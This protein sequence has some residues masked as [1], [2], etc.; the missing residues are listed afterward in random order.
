MQALLFRRIL[1]E[2]EKTVRD[3]FR[4]A[5]EFG[6][7]DVDR[8]LS[9]VDRY[10]LSKGKEAMFELTNSDAALTM[11]LWLESAGGADTIR[12][13]FRI[14]RDAFAFPR[15]NKVHLAGHGPY[16]LSRD[17][18]PR[19]PAH[20]IKVTAA[21]MNTEVGK[22]AEM[23]RH[24]R[25]VLISKDPEKVRE[26]KWDLEQACKGSRVWHVD[27]HDGRRFEVF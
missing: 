19:I 4:D 11:E 5:R 22:V 26:A 10:A 12:R 2:N 27:L 20:A 23:L 13:M 7:E 3:F 9:S 16:W 14:Q 24:L 8:F 6:P 1:P 17:M 15:G 21:V 18:S 25:T